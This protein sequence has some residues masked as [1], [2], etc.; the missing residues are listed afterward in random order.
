MEA[1]KELFLLLVI[2]RVYAWLTFDKCFLCFQGWKD[3][4]ILSLQ[5]IAYSG[6]TTCKGKLLS[7]IP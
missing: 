5:K 1:I 4:L 2:Q 7:C 3:D 6:L